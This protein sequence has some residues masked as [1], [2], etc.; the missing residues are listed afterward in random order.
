MT[1]K[2]IIKGVIDDLQLMTEDDLPFSKCDE[3]CEDCE[4]IC[5]EYF[6][7]D[8]LTQIEV[9]HRIARREYESTEPKYRY[10]CANVNIKT[11][12]DV[13]GWDDFEFTKPKGDEE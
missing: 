3:D 8:A 12:C 1:N 7:E 2:D 6:R 9:L 5:V 4:N 13:F 11:L 10:N